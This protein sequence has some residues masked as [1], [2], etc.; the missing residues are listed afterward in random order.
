MP[1]VERTLDIAAPPST[2]WAW[3]S[4]PERL[5]RWLA[6]SLD[7]D[8]REGGS[9]RMRGADDETWISGTVLELV[10]E[11]R[12]VLSWLEEDAGWLNPGRLVVA[13]TAVP[14]GTRISLV[15]DGFAGIGKPGWQATRQAYERGADKHL[16]L[17]QLAAVVAGDQGA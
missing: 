13:L 7:I 2:V 4:T 11:G 15:H 17:Q 12:L 16:I 8:L 9:Y 10:P 6:P 5:R 3:F 14:A 1:Q